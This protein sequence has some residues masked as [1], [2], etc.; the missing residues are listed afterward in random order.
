MK[1]DE[2]VAT[3][4]QHLRANATTYSSNPELKEYW[5]AVRKTDKPE[6]TE[7]PVKKPLKNALAP[8]IGEAEPP[9]KKAERRKT[10]GASGDAYCNP[11][12]DRDQS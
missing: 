6:P 1:K 5:T 3:L 9:K 12:F 7:S 8:I 2:L 4:D 10:T 11:L